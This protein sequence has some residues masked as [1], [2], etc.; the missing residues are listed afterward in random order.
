MRVEFIHHF[1][2]TS[3]FPYL[4]SHPPLKKKKKHCT[5]DD[6]GDMNI[7]LETKICAVV[8]F[9]RGFVLGGIFLILFL[10]IFNKT[11]LVNINET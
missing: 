6:D 11:K 7:P 2:T 4:Y 5:I 9:M 3:F 8:A 1:E 10:I